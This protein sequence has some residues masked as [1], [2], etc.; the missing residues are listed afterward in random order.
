MTNEQDKAIASGA[1]HVEQTQYLTAGL[2]SP[3][4]VS[5]EEREPEGGLP[6]GPVKTALGELTLSMFQQGQSV[7]VRIGNAHNSSELYERVFPSADEANDALLQ[8]DILTDAQVPDPTQLAGMG[9]VLASVTAE[10]LES[11][12]LKR[13]GV[14]TL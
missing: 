13:H 11:A 4:D 1:K 2:E 9:I 10:Q 3:R 12:G 8:A 7:R 5:I 14:S 6:G